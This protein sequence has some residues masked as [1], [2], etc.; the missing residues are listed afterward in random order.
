MSWSNYKMPP[1]EGGDILKLEDGKAIK[2]QVNG[3]PYV[4]QG[5]Y[6]GKLSTRFALK[7]WNFEANKAQ[8]LM[9]P[10]T[11]FGAIMDLAN[12][13]EWGDPDTYPI[14]FK[15]TGTGKETEWSV[16]PSPN[17]GKLSK[18]QTDQLDTIDLETVLKKLPSVQFAMPMSEVDD[19]FP[20]KAQGV[21][22]NQTTALTITDEEGNPV[23]TIDGD[24]IPF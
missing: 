17:K 14:T 21:Q 15:R 13:P 5:D 23:G 4:Y 8:I 3:E 12:N 1:S 11:A 6:Q 7:V 24:D 10:K 2:L 9:M 19:D 20:K 22:P 16:Q 18:E